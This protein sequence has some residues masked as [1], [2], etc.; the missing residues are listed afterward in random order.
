MS[1]CDI[2]ETAWRRRPAVGFVRHASEIRIA[3]YDS[4][5]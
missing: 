1:R 4:E 3:A 5:R 2:D